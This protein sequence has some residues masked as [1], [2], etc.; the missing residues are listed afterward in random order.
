[1]K[2]TPLHMTHNNQVQK[3]R[4]LIL[5]FMIMLALSGITAFPIETE[6]HFLLTHFRSMP[7]RLKEWIETVYAAVKSTNHQY[8]FLQYGYD[9]LAFA[10]LMIALFFIGPYRDPV[11][12]VW[13]IEWGMIAC[14]C[15]LPL[16][17]ICGRYVVS[18]F[19]GR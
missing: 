14:A 2:S 15:V 5:F 1:M 8:P 17:L 13:V 4:R 12:N 18:P 19:I 16:A 6:L 9:W 11:K 7:A 3:V 10:H